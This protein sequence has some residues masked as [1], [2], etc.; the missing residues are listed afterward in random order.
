M[1]FD[2]LLMDCDF[3]CFA[4]VFRTI[5]IYFLRSAAASVHCYLPFFM[6]QGKTVKRLWKISALANTSFLNK[7]STR[8]V[9]NCCQRCSMR[10]IWGGW[11][12]GHFRRGARRAKLAELILTLNHTWNKAATSKKISSIFRKAFNLKEDGEISFQYLR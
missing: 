2:Y 4:I 10:V 1:R 3:L 9:E 5:I 11:L 7:V 8:R 12:T 6:A